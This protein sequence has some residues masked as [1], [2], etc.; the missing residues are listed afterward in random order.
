MRRG[1]VYIWALGGTPAKETGTIEE[2]RTTTINHDMPSTSHSQTVH[3]KLNSASIQPWSAC[4]L[5]PKHTLPIWPVDITLYITTTYVPPDVCLFT[6]IDSCLNMLAY[7]RLYQSIYYRL[8]VF[9]SLLTCYA[10]ATLP[11][12]TIHSRL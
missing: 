5:N 6:L 3:E 8:N 2:Q 9:C 10:C 11:H 7:N 4:V 12:T 1:A